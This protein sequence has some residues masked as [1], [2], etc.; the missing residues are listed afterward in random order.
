MKPRKNSIGK[1]HFF[2]ISNIILQSKLYQQ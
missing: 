1:K 2:T